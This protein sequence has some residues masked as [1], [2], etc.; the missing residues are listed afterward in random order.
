MPDQPLVSIII[1]TF[2]RAHLLGETL[3]SVLAQTYPNWEC[4]VVDDGSTDGT[5][6][7]LNHYIAKDSRFQYHKR[8]ETHLPGGNGARNYGFQVSNGEYVQWFDDDDV[9]LLDFIH[10]KIV[11]FDRPLQMVICTGY[12]ASPD[13]NRL[14]IAKVEK[15]TYLFKDYVLWNCHILTPS[16]LFKKT[17]LEG[18]DLF[19]SIISRGQETEFYSRLFY[20]IEPEAFLILHEPLFLYRQHVKTKSS[21]NKKYVS[22]FK[23]SQSYINVENLKRSIVIRDCELINHCL[24][25]L[26][27]YFFTSLKHDD[28][29]TAAY[30]YKQLCPILKGKNKLVYLEFMFF[31]GFLLHF[32]T[33]SYKLYKRWKN[34][35]LC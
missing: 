26:M 7:L 28:F 24:Q 6:E 1:P 13:L 27:I 34:F 22:D 20:N 19:S 17:F 18:K 10:S 31:G 32:K 12:Y 25:T 23:F 4:L 2:N 16:I 33:K 30:I 14:D 11:V 15:Q 29:N 5:A 8:P 9:M 35:E 21:Q 3:D